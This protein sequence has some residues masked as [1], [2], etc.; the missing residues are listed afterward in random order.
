MGYQVKVTKG[1]PKFFKFG[2]VT[3]DD[4]IFGR[5]ADYGVVKPIVLGLPA[6]KN[7]EGFTD[8]FPIHWKDRRFFLL[9]ANAGIASTP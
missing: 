5:V 1:A 7:G 4:D 3:I 2:P 6:N 9:G 8:P